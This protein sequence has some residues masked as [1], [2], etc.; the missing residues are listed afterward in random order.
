MVKESNYQSKKHKRQMEHCAAMRAQKHRLCEFSIES[1]E[2]STSPQ[3]PVLCSSAAYKKVDNIN[4]SYVVKLEILTTS[5]RKCQYCNDGPLDLANICED[6][7]S[8]GPIPILKVKCSCCQNI[9]TLWPAES[10]RT[11]KRG[12]EA[13]DINSRAALGAL[14]SGM[15]H[16][17]YSGLLSTLGLRPLISR[18]YKK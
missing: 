11:G 3:R 9:K 6:V 15:G 2:T 13:L 5:V 12:P 18:N 1:N 14:H 16:T 17:H 7:R 4:H 8:E 10:H